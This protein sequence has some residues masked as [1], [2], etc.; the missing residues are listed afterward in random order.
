MLGIALLALTIGV[1]GPATSAEYLPLRLAAAEGLFAAEGAAVTLRTFPSE[2]AA[3]E[4]LAKG[5]VD[6]AA[7]SVD[8]ALRLGHVRGTPPRLVLGLTAAP[9]VALL[10]AS[11]V[12]QEVR[13]L[14]HLAGRT[15]GIPAPG[16]PEAEALTWL[17][18][19]AK[20]GPPRTTTQ[21][22]GERA[23]AAAL[24][25][26]ELPA[27]VLGD[28]WASR[29]LQEGA[30]ALAD[31]RRRDE[32]KRWLGADVV[33]AAIFARAGVTPPAAELGAIRRAVARAIARLREAEPEALAGALQ[34]AVVGLPEDWRARV[35]G[36]REIYLAD[37]RVTAEGLETALQLAER[38]APLPAAV[39]MPW[40]LRSLL[41]E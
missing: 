1:A 21:S 6:L 22:H 11:G 40:R 9:P 2:A 20:I 28:P 27:G 5:Q 15:V 37:G 16:T 41:L 10:V 13:E 36:A 19:R 18:E 3:A 12:R 17:L 32:V 24:A 26:G 31:L 33:H 38:R 39:K 25:S 35:L 29:L 8:A 30:V 14:A 23:L 7:T 4:A 34:G